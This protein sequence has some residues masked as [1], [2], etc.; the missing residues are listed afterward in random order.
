MRISI[1]SVRKYSGMKKFASFLGFS[2]TF[3]ALYLAIYVVHSWYFPVNVVL[4]SALLDAAIAV[5]L[6]AVVLVLL[7]PP[8]GGFEQFLMICVWALCGYCI[9]ISGPAV[10]DRSLSFY[11]I[12]KL[13]QR[14]GG[15]EQARMKDMFISEFIPES[16]LMDVRLTEQLNSATVTLEDG[17]VKLTP[18]G[19][20]LATVSRFLR[21]NF[22]PKK[23]EL[24]GEYS[25]ALT[26][27][28]RD[29][30]VGPMGYECN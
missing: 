9:A 24:L 15:I 11:I 4:Y 26:D 30:P 13:Q 8:L 12:E 7:R 21:M 16:R 28:F 22:L 1:D 17:C 18:L 5:V 10:L 25:D 20:T 23:R 27:P 14:G 19:S 2:T 3:I 6:S 29:S